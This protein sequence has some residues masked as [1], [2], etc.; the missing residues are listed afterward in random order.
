MG[1]DQYA[2]AVEILYGVRGR[3]GMSKDLG[4]TLMDALMFLGR[5]E[6]A[7]AISFSSA[8]KEPL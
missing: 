5:Y 7:R 1:L 4:E 3:F 8:H 6:E 2:E